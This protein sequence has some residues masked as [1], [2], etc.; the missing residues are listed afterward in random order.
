MRPPVQACDGGDIG[1]AVLVVEVFL[2]GGH[3]HVLRLAVHVELD[4]FWGLAFWVGVFGHELERGGGR[5][6]VGIDIVVHDFGGIVEVRIFS[7]DEG[8]ADAV[9]LRGVVAIGGTEN[10]GSAAPI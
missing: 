4:G 2:V 10:N 7:V 8:S 1:D 3:G 9:G 6:A 5:A